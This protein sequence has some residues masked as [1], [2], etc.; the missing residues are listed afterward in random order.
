MLFAQS[1]G[2]T[3][4]MQDFVAGAEWKKYE[5]PFAGFAGVDG[6]DVLGIAFTGGPTPGAFSMQIDEVVLR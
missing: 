6:S 3:P 5:F 4:I 1:K 2:M